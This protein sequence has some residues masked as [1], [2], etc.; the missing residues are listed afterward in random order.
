MSSVTCSFTAVSRTKA[1]DKL[2]ITLSARLPMR[3][4]ASKRNI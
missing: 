4:P 1:C 2:C 3:S